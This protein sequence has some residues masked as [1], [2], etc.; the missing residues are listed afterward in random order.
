MQWIGIDVSKEHLDGFARPSGAS[1]RF[2]NDDV[3]Q[4]ALCKWVREL[5]TCHV[6]MEPT[7]GYERAV[8]RELLS[9]HV[10][11]SVVNARQIRDFA[12]A[13]GRLAKT[14]KIDAQVI[15][16]FGEA[17]GPQARTQKDSQAELLEA[18]L[19]RRRQLIE[20]CVMEKNRRALVLPALRDKITAVIQV[21]VEQIA[22]LDDELDQLIK[23]SPVWKEHEELLLS[24]PGVGH[25]TARTMATMVP[26]LGKL[27]RKQIAALVGVAPFN[28]DSGAYRGKRHIRGGRGAVRHVLYMAALS[29]TKHNPVLRALYER[30]C[31]AGKLHKVALVACM[32]K[33]LCILNAMVK[34]QSPW[35]LAAQTH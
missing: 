22:Q 5:G 2:A 3:G 17:M 28:H 6:V 16:H 19:V 10:T 33:L 29:G 25:V 34:H 21:L 4:A 35:H 9:A 30:L 27:N 12:R 31:H 14:D 23:G 13:T 20:M 1:V 24:V 18:L 8:L 11:V 32:R 26:E 7:G 15:A